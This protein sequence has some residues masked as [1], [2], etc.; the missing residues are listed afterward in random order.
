MPTNNRYILVRSFTI[1][2]LAILTGM[3]AS[4]QSPKP[5]RPLDYPIETKYD[6]FDNK[7]SIILKYTRVQGETRDSLD[8]ALLTAYEGEKLTAPIKDVALSIASTSSDWRYLR[9]SRT[10]RVIADGERINLG[11]MERR[12]STV[13][14]GYVM[15]FMGVFISSDTLR[16]IA[17]SKKVEMQLGSIEFELSKEM[18]GYMKDFAALL[19]P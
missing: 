19:N 3:A 4:A 10:L 15:E 16:K 17:N 18:L 1:C 7:T 5:P 6:R 2:L 8:M 14:R 13:G 9:G 11:E 12:N